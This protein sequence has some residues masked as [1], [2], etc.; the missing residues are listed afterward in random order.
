MPGSVK[1]HRDENSNK[2]KPNKKSKHDS[3]ETSASS[4]NRKEQNRQ[5]AYR[6][7]IK[8]KNYVSTLEAQ[9]KH[10]TAENKKLRSSSEKE[11]QQL[12][13]HAEMQNLNSF[14]QSQLNDIERLNIRIIDLIALNQEYLDRFNNMH[15]NPMVQLLQ[16]QVEELTR[17]KKNQDETIK[18]LVGAIEELKKQLI[19]QYQTNQM[20]EQQQTSQVDALSAS[21]GQSEQA[22]PAPELSN[23]SQ[24]SMFTGRSSSTTYPPA[25]PVIEVS[26]DELSAQQTTVSQP[27]S[28][29]LVFG[30]P[31][32][33]LP[34]A[35][36]H[37]EDTFF[38][39]G[40][41]QTSAVESLPLEEISNVDLPEIDNLFDSPCF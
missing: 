14:L 15:Q 8:R 37:C 27:P 21:N 22:Y 11:D 5:A 28:K 26:T 16:N 30:R 25:S 41:D 17:Q 23:V 38:G 10:L 6:S 12:E 31:I 34:V 18:V 4:E 39:E 20:Q 13:A 29:M 40:L 2:T 3:Q 19:L 33:F 35:N 9:I 32:G 24:F 7:R 1:R 36:A